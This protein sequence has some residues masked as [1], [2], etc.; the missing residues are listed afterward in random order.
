MLG[1]R[2]RAT[3]YLVL[4]F[5]CGALS[6]A[7]AARWLERISV[8]AD[9]YSDSRP[10]ETRKGAVKWFTKGLDLNPQQME[11]LTK[12]L[13]E[14]RAAYKDHELQIESIKQHARVRIR[15][16]LTDPQKEVYDRLLAERAQRDREKDS[17]SSR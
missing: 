4:I 17:R 6:G 9:S 1:M 10:L 7:L 3:L 5:L 15:E 2:S 13:E 11:Q 12:I 8:S 16:I 14:T